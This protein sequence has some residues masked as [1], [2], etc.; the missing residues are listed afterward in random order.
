MKKKTTRHGRFNSMDTNTDGYH[1]DN[2]ECA[3]DTDSDGI[4]SL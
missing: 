3:L 2:E 4:G 1:K